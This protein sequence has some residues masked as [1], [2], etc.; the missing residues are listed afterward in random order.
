MALTT[1]SLVI[2]GGDV[3]KLRKDVQ[4][5]VGPV[6]IMADEA[7]QDNGTHAWSLRGNVRMIPN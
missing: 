1:S 6:T 4:I 3:T 5:N 7:D 2:T